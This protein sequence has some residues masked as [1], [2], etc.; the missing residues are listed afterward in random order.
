MSHADTMSPSRKVL[1]QAERLG[2][3]PQEAGPGQWR[4]R[5]PVHK[6][7]SRNLSIRE[8]SDGAVLLRCHHAENGV[9]TCSAAAVA[10]EL[11]L[12]L[13]DLFPASDRPKKKERAKPFVSAEASIAALTRRLGAPTTC[14]HY[15]QTDGGHTTE[16]MRV[17]RFDASDG[18]KQFRPVHATGEG[19]FLGDPPGFLP[20][21]HLPEIGG[22]K[23]VVVVEGEKCAD[24]LS[25]LGLVV[26]TSA[27]GA[28]SAH[29]SDWTPLAGKDIAIIPDHDEAGESYAL[30]VAGLLSGLSPVP[31]IRIVRLPLESKGDDAEQWIRDV[32]PD[33]WDLNDCRIDLERL[34][35]KTPIWVAPEGL[36]Q[37]PKEPPNLTEW[38]NAKRLVESHGK[39]IRYV[40]PMSRWM[41][42]DKTRWTNDETG[43]IWRLAKQ[44]PKRLCEEA[45]ASFDSQTRE[46]VMRWALQSERKKVL[47]ASLDLAWSEEG[48][49]V[50]PGDFDADPGVVNTPS[51]VVDLSTGALEEARP[52]QMLSKLTSEPFEAKRDCPLW[53][54]VLSEVFD[55]DEELIAYLQRAVGYSLTGDTSEHCMFMCYGSGR[56]GKNTVLDTIRTILG[57]YATV[58]DPRLFLASGQGDHPAGLADLVGRRLVMTSEVDEGQALAEGLVKRVTGDKVIKARFMHQNP[59]EFA[60][61]FKLWM[62]VNDKPD[63]NKQEEGIWSRI[64][65]IP[66]KVFIPPDKRIKGLSERLIAEEG[67]GILAWIVEGA[68]EWARQGL[69]EPSAVTDATESYR[70]EQDVIG[71]FLSETC[72]CHLDHGPCTPCR[73]AHGPAGAGKANGA[74]LYERY[75]AW[76]T[77][78]GIRSVPTQKRF[79]A[80]LTRRG[81]P[82]V[83][84]NSTRGRHGLS[85]K[86]CDADVSGHSGGPESLF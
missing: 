17:Y 21:Y 83:T 84:S 4:S 20:L 38:G 55:G 7:K 74:V 80:D 36:S 13:R 14:W 29:K 52:E 5:C 53:R 28:R 86:H 25:Q 50:M 22:A 37:K 85:L 15:H 6:G 62:L 82:S 1:A 31:T 8:T 26:T 2:L 44:L 19:W 72:F 40:Y 11:G 43:A 64:R 34:W 48:I 35:A 27:H 33:S 9:S 63:I 66:F 32:V 30:A 68:R 18:T 69:N 71:D 76:A 61:T 57:D 67:P 59:F 70:E 39:V 75:V 46:N 65:I 77:R 42:W 16:V 47:Q 3:E 23:R 12:S 56:N 60:V 10:R 81:Y 79:G 58:A 49:G 45:A 51:G 24:L 78:N 73:M 54:R 41:I